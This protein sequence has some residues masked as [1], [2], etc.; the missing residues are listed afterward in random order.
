MSSIVAGTPQAYSGNLTISY[1][2][3]NI[4][5]GL[6]TLYPSK[7]K[8]EGHEYHRANMSRVGTQKVCK[9]TGAV[10]TA[11]DI[12]PGYEIGDV[13]VTLET[14]ARDALAALATQTIDL[15]AYVPVDSIDRANVDS[16]YI[17]Q[18]RK[19]NGKP[20]MQLLA[21]LREDPTRALVGTYVPSRSKSTKVLMIRWCEEEGVALAHSCHYEQKKN[22]AVLD[23]I[24]RIN[25][26]LDAPT[27]AEVAQARMMF[28]S[29]DDTFDLTAVRDDYEDA[30]EAAID[31]QLPGANDE[32]VAADLM[33][34]LKATV[35]Q[36]STKKEKVTA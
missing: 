30:L 28:G 22:H 1:G 31:A 10:L 8:Y 6:N 18:P 27:E 12:I 25:E 24:R 19:G 13:I 17:V 5:I 21:M 34:N 2:L 7:A 32:Q 26:E 3:A 9:T 29:L 33:A 23:T 4:E 14:G 36:K 20:Y 15:T 35:K 16:T 11:D